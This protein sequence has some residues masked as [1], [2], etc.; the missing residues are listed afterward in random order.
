MPAHV[1]AYIAA[2]IVANDNIRRGDN[3]CCHAPPALSFS[4]ACR[5]Y[6]VNGLASDVLIPRPYILLFLVSYR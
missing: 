5:A 3:V 1:A 6:T 2:W 4:F